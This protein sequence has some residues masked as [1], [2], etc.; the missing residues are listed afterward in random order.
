MKIRNSLLL[1]SVGLVLVLSVSCNKPVQKRYHLTGRVV[2][3]DKR[4]HSVMVDGDD[5]PGFMAAMTMPYTV[6]DDSL[7]DKLSPGDQITADVVVSGD[8][9]WLENIVVTGHSAPPK[10]TSE[11]HIPAPGEAVPDFKFVNQDG[12]RISLDQYRGKALLLTF[13]YTRCPFPNFCPRVSHEFAEINRQ[14][15][16]DAT[17]SGKTHLLS[18]T[19]DPAHDTPKVLRAYGFSCAGGKQPSLFRHWEFAAPRVADLPAIARFFAVSY[20]QEGNVINH[21][22]STAVIGPDG[23]I[24]KW[25]HGVDWQS[26]E[27][28]KDAADALHTNS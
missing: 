14:L 8:S 13:I 27:L 21:S 6:K 2:S 28:L 4:S 10:P 9:S 25:Y 12:R 20:S 17:L 3:T 16:G 5:I 26:S 15:E 7:L 1:F 18:V 19:F 11:L 22:L 23:R 24:F